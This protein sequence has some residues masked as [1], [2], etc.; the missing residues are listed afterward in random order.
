MDKSFCDTLPLQ[1]FLQENFSSSSFGFSLFGVATS[2]NYFPFV[3][4]DCV[5]ILGS[6]PFH[7]FSRQIHP[8]SPWPSSIPSTWH[9][10]LHHP[11]SH[12]AFFSP[13]H[14]S[15]QRSLAFRSLS[16]SFAIF[17]VT[18]TYLFLILSFLITP[19]AHLTIFNSAT[20][21][22]PTCLF[23]TATISIPLSMA[24]LTTLLYIL[25]S[26][27]GDNFLSHRTQATF[28]QLIHPAWILFLTSSSLLPSLPSI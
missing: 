14:V 27:L 19:S 9:R 26:T 22:F 3:P 2:Q 5:S 8:P 15:I 28:F 16:P 7:V 18:L 6:D 20:S 21:I 10:H 23:V 17:A 13:F 24:G 12:V 1:S 11:F 25:P 4:I